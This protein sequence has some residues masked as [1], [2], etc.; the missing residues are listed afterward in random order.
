MNGHAYNTRNV[1]AGKN[2]DGQN[3]AGT[4]EDALARERATEQHVRHPRA[5]K[6]YRLEDAV[7]DAQ[8]GSREQV[9]EQRVAEEIV[10]HHEH[11]ER[12][13]DEPIDLARTAVRAREE[14]AAQVG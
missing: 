5:D 1:A 6:R 8:A 14:D 4:R 13:A 11:E 2:T 9:V 10:H 12:D 3:A 7:R